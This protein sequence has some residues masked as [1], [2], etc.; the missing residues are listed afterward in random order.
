MDGYGWTHEHLDKQMPLNQLSHR[1]M[2]R[3][4]WNTTYPCLT[5]IFQIEESGPGVYDSRS[6]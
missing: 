2:L 1:K 3:L 6:H 4:I 5:I